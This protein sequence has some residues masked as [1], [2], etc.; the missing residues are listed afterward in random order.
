MIPD[1]GNFGDDCVGSFKDEVL[2][3]CNSGRCTLTVANITSTS[4]E[5]IV[6]NVVSY[7]LTIHAGESLEVPVRFQPASFGP[8]S[9]TLTVVSDDP[10]GPAIVAVSGNAP[11]GKLAVTG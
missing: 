2:T 10:S 4:G 9:A 5:F 8:K 11:A 1:A 6:P 3:L 7:P